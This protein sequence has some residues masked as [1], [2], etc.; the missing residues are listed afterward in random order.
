MSHYLLNWLANLASDKEV[1]F[2]A[3][4][5]ACFA[6]RSTLMAHPIFDFTALG[7]T[8]SSVFL[9]SNGLWIS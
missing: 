6:G 5:A 8:L 3:R 4:V 7:A 2:V 1:A 9:N